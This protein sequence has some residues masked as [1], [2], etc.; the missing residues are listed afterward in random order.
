MGGGQ[1][2]EKAL[3]ERAALELQE[4]LR[5]AELK[6]ELERQEKEA[7]E[8]AAKQR[9]IDLAKEV[10]EVPI[11][12]KK[13]NEMDPILEDNESAA[14]QKEEEEGEEEREEEQEM[15]PITPEPDSDVIPEDEWPMKRDPPRITVFD[16][17]IEEIL[18]NVQKELQEKN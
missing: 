1:A 15:R 11:E 8:H 17:E 5:Q 3:K 2:K 14:L 12:E 9:E 16:D 6:A 10:P 18:M 7:A 4:R 13:E